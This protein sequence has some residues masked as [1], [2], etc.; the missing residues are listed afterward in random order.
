MPVTYNLMKNGINFTNHYSFTSG[1]GSTFN[2]EFMVNT[3]Y[4][5]A[6]III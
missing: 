5:T 4:S 1:G 2:S 3:G 6:L